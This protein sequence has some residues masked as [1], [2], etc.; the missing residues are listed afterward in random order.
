MRFFLATTVGL[1]L[2]LSV[3]VPTGAAGSWANVTPSNANVTSGLDCGSFGTQSVMVDPKRP[4]DMY[5]NFNCQGI[6]KST[7]F[8]QTWTGPINTGTGGQCAGDSAGVVSIAPGSGT[9]PPTLYQGSIRGCGNGFWR[10]LDGGVSWQNFLIGPAPSGR[11][12]I[13]VPAVDPYD[14]S[15]LIVAAHELNMMYQSVDG[16]QTWTNVVQN[17]GMNEQ[18]GTALVTFINTG[19]PATTRNT[20]LWIAQASGGTYGTWRTTNGGSAWTKVDSNEHGH[21][22]GQVY[23]PDSLGTVYMAGVYSAKG[24]GVLRSTDYGATWAHVGNNGSEN[25]VFG[26]TS[27]IFTAWGWAC[28]IGCDVDPSMWVAPLPGLSWAAVPRPAG[29]SQGPAEA[30]MTFDGMNSIIVSANWA[31][32]L[33]RFSEPGVGPTA[34][35]TAQPTGT[36]VATSTPTAAPTSTPAPTV[37]A[38]PVPSVCQVVVVQNGVETSVSRPASFCTDQ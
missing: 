16:G 5:A 19:N 10:S 1:L 8:G 6:W 29:M 14:G 23:Q 20:W 37:T 11:Q 4:S 27:H 35:P 28:G 2:A 31:A 34:T 25:A 36:P 12:D 13:Y 32:G 24:W 30:A 22:S 7:D 26:T 15:H 38:T 3:A 9:N 17:S 33:W 21:G 18:G